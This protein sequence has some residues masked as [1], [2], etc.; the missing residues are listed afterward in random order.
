[1]SAARPDARPAPASARVAE[2]V[3]GEVA[4]LLGWGG[5]ILLQLAHPLVARGVADH[6]GFRGDAR[7]SW[8]RLHRTLGAMLALTFGGQEGAARAA[9][10]INAIHDRVHGRL[11]HPEGPYPAGTTYSAHDPELLRWVHAACLVMF[12]DAYERYVRPLSREERDRY[13][14]ESSEV[15]PLLSIPTGF[16]PRSSAELA[17]CM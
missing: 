15:E 12:M 8:R 14:A 9:R 6:S 5:A 17:T 16:L 1:M 4:V 10:G 11:A 2:R 7:A 3:H 13:C